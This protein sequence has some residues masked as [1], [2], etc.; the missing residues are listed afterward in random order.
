MT[1]R[2]TRLPTYPL[3]LFRVR[4]RSRGN[5]YVLAIPSADTDMATDG[6]ILL[7]SQS[8]NEIHI[9]YA[10]RDEYELGPYPGS[11]RRANREGTAQQRTDL[12]GVRIDPREASAIKPGIGFALHGLVADGY[13]DVVA[14]ISVV[15]YI[16]G[17]GTIVDARNSG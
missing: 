11:I 7:A 12:A 10:S 13:A 14:E 17:G 15:D 6:L 4:S 1:L 3:K 9:C 16:A 8:R 5:E 2:R